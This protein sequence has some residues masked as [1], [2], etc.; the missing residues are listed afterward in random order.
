MITLRHHVISL[1]AVFLALAIGVVLGSG[2][3]SNTTLAGLRDDKGGLQ[4]Q[5]GTL[6][7]RNK[8]LDQRLAAANEFDTMIAG[9]AVRDALAGRSVLIVRTPDA[10]DEDVDAVA[11]LAAGAGATVTG[12]IGLTGEFV[13]AD[14]A[15]KLRTVVNSPILPAGRQLDTGLTDP[16]AQAGDLLGM[17][18][19]IHRDAKIAPVDDAARQT[20][21]TTLADTG[22]LTA[23]E[24]LAPADTAVVV[25][26]GPLPED[27]GSQGAAV[28]RLAAG[29]APHGSGTVLAGREG[30]ATGVAAVAVAR[31]DP[32]IARVLS[33]V[34]DIGAG[35]GRITTVLALRAMID[36]APAEAYGTGRGAAALTV[37]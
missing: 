16:A 8:T 26:G 18:L 14:S 17:A 15:E 10:A 25:T 5:V 31:A 24:R 36:G 4:R 27:A 9:R 3:L 7:D 22:F 28:A 29:M 2:A 6:D 20:V 33:T 30:S 21:L 19:L 37:G 13:G 23:G 35:A 12:T 32:G 34:D 1:A 11:G